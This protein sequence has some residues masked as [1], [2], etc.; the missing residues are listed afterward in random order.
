MTH[1]LA[2]AGPSQRPL[3]H[4]SP[5][6]TLYV[7][8]EKIL[9]ALIANLE[10]CKIPISLD[11]LLEKAKDITVY[12]RDFRVALPSGT[13]VIP[14]GLDMPNFQVKTYSLLPEASD[15]CITLSGALYGKGFQAKNRIQAIQFANE[16]KIPYVE[17]RSCIEGGNCRIVPGLD[18]APRAIIGVHSLVASLLALEQQQYFSSHLM[19]SYKQTPPPSEHSFRMARNSKI[20]EKEFL[21]VYERYNS[22]KTAMERM[23]SRSQV[24]NLFCDE[25]LLSNTSFLEDLNP[26][27][28]EE[29]AP[30]SRKRSFSEI[31]SDSD[32]GQISEFQQLLHEHSSALLKIRRSLSKYTQPLTV[33]DKEDFLSQ[34]EEWQTKLEITKEVI[35]SELGVQKE[36]LAIVDQGEF[37]IDMEIF[38]TKNGVAFI[39]DE[40]SCLFALQA[41]RR[42][43]ELQSPNSDL[44]Q[45]IEKYENASVEREEACTKRNKRIVEALQSIGCSVNLISGIYRAEGEPTLNFMNGFFLESGGSE[46]FITNGTPYDLVIFADYFAKALRSS[47]PELKSCFVNDQKSPAIMQEFL[48][49]NGGIRCITW[50]VLNTN[51]PRNVDLRPYS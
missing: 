26:Q 47:H 7:G 27:G 14:Y 12:G 49:R 43:V 46:H 28:P 8:N 35:T 2:S 1:A 37:H 31:Q 10:N 17:A 34:A 19:Q 18:G 5:S 20:Y 22:I 38:T 32:E 16:H 3:H 33:Y 29:E 44:L 50:E 40:R 39:H 21:P 51:H 42:A 23:Q 15:H 41:I 4:V 6:Q 36:H 13:Q 11:P 24:L 25:H 9:G 48:A 45:V 30:F